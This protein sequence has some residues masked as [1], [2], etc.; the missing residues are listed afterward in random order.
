LSQFNCELDEE[1]TAVTT[2]NPLI[3]SKT[4][5]LFC[6]GTLW[7]KPDEKEPTDGRLLIFTA[8]DNDSQSRMT[9]L[10]LSLVASMHVKGCVYSLAVV[11]GM[12]AAAVNASVSS[13][14][15]SIQTQLTN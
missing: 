4:M 3:E 10:Q 1:I 2:M 8:Y 9:T 13:C 5:P 15:R 7:Y 12:I 6:L 14:K 11:N